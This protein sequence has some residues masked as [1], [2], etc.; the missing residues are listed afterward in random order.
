[1]HSGVDVLTGLA[2]TASLPFRNQQ[3]LVLGKSRRWE[4]AIPLHVIC[5]EARLVLDRLVNDIQ[6]VQH[7]EQRRLPLGESVR[8]FPQVFL[9][10]AREEPKFFDEIFAIGKAKLNLFSSSHSCF[11]FGEGVKQ[12]V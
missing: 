2:Q 8:H 5:G 11:H 4:G 6:L 9:V 12:V 7:G 10:A 1:V 3:N